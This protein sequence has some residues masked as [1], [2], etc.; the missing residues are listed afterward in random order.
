MPEAFVKTGPECNQKCLFC[1]TTEDEKVTTLQAKAAIDK[2]IGKGYSWISFTGGEPTIRGD[3]F[4]LIHYAKKKGA[5]IIK[6]QTNGILTANKIF[7]DKLVS[8]GMNRA[9]MSV[10]SH[11]KE[12][13]EKLTQTPNSFEKAIL[14][15]K[16][17]MALKIPLEMSCVITTLNYSHLKEYVAF[18]HSNFSGIESYQ[19]LL[20]CPL[21]RGH[22]NKK[23]VPK[24]KYIEQPLKDMLEFCRQNNIFAVTRG[25]PLCYLDSF[26]NMSV[27]TNAILSTNKKM[28]ISDF[29][30]DVSRH[31]FEDSNSKAPQCKFC[32]LN[33]ICGGT[34]TKYLELYSAQELFPVYKKAIL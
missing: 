4:E 7:L 30:D 16:N 29:K 34:W 9:Y 22:E 26:E 31:S 21:A 32:W 23:F 17:I 12:V 5:K 20:F 13:H 19:F 1:Y 28:I 33:K 11:K 8:A 27:E 6:V 2:Y 3:L 25:I 10:L 24:L 15:V 14:S 18:M